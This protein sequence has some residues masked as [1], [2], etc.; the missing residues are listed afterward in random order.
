MNDEVVVV[1]GGPAGAACAL[2]L[3]RAGV[4]VSVVDRGAPPRAT[5]ESLPP[6]ANPLLETLGIAQHLRADGH[7]AC[8]GNR[9]AWAE[10]APVERD[11]VFDRFGSGWLIDRS[12][13][14]ARLRS[15]AEAAGARWI[16]DVAVLGAA[17]AGE[18]VELACDDGRR[19]TPAF[20]VDASGRSAIV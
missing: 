20:V 1:G 15:L 11:D 18:R 19:I 4:T 2:L 14:D 3:A 13:F 10:G 7:L 12:R 8:A 9:F 16:A 17:P 6:G 5:T